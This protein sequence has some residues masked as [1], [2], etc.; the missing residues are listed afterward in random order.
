MAGE[1]TRGTRVV[2]WVP[3]ARSRAMLPGRWSTT[4]QTSR[5]PRES[6]ARKSRIVCTDIFADAEGNPVPPRYYGMS[7]DLSAEALIMVTVDGHEGQDEAH[8]AL[9][10]HRDRPV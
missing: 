3:A 5:R 1:G 7:P 8:A 4:V 9:L 6:I 10:A 2:K